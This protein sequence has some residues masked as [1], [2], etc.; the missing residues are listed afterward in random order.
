MMKGHEY[1]ID[2]F[3]QKGHSEYFI[4]KISGYYENKKGFIEKCYVKLGNLFEELDDYVIT[5]SILKCN[6]SN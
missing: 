1:L 3:I 4:R 6:L 2:A 5:A